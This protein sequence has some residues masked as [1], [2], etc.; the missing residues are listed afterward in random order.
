MPS[1]SARP[2]C[3]ACSTHRARRRGVDAVRTWPASCATEWTDDVTLVTFIPSPAS[4]VW[5][6]GPVPL[7]AY[8]LG[9]IIGALLAIWIGEKRSS[10]AAAGPA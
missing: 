5:H 4:G 3:G 9:I 2:W 1:S 10:R 8:A 7:R 6:L